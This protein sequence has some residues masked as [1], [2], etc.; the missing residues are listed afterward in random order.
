MTYRCRNHLV[1]AITAPL[2]SLLP[3]RPKAQ[4]PKLKSSCII[5]EIMTNDGQGL[6]T[7]TTDL[8][9]KGESY[10][11]IKLS[12]SSLGGMHSKEEIQT[13]HKIQTTMDGL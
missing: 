9:C 7:N 1:K 5:W 3:A 13:K 8:R 10:T 11:N 6:G 12:K 2:P 4:T